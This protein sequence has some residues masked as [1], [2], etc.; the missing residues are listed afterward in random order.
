MV[1]LP[2]TLVHERRGSGDP[3]VLVHGVGSRWQVWEPVLEPLAAAGYDVIAVDLP[4]FGESRQDGTEPTIVAQALRV[5][6][7][8]EEIGVERPH[9]AGNSMGG[10]IALELARRG[11]VRTATAVSPAGFW[12]DRE[13]AFCQVSLRMSKALLGLARPIVPALVATGPMRAALFSQFFARPWRMSPEAAVLAADGLLAAPSFDA[14][15][16][17]FSNYRFGRPDELRDVPVTI[18]WGSRDF[19]LL[20]REGERARRMLPWAQFIELRG[21]GH[22]PFSDDPDVLVDTLLRGVRAERRAAFPATR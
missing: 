8:F 10:A 20:P 22:A 15:V 1:P 17:E 11:S 6:R 13:R 7:F 21:L 3:L 19:L 4:G 5:E 16:A 2:M 18:A 14:A 12:T 9:V